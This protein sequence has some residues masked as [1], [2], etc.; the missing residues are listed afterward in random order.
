MLLGILFLTYITAGL[1]MLNVLVHEDQ[2]W[3]YFATRDPEGEIRMQGVATAPVDSDYSRSTWT[4]RC[5]ESILKP[6]LDW[7]GK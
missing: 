3:L 2:L 4:Q 5:T 7:E 6:E 1:L